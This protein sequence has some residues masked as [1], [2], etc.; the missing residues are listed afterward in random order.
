MNNVILGTVHRG[1]NSIDSDKNV[2]SQQAIWTAQS[3]S[4]IKQS[5]GIFDK[6]TN[7]DAFGD[8]HF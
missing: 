2:Y 5:V 3:V 1:A 4:S 8:G 6:R 7:E